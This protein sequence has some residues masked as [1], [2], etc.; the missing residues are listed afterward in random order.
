MALIGVLASGG[1]SNLQSIIDNVESGWIPDSQVVVVVSDKK[2]AYALE[3]AESHGIESLHLDPSGYVSREDYDKE[4]VKEL[5]KRDV[6]L[7][8]LAG[9]MR[10]ITPYFVRAFKDRLMN[11]HPALLPSFP[12]VHGQQQAFDYGV[13]V[14]GCTVHFVDE[15]VD[16]GPIIVQA[17][18]P[19]L[20]GDDVNSLAGRILE[21]EHLIYPQA[22]KWYVEGR[23]TVEGRRVRVR[24][25]EQAG[26]GLRVL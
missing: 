3:R 5:G 23:L 16:H 26:R 8:L 18:V 22:V 15:E 13:K 10:I 12:G 20:E 9:Y 2:D 17:A 19:V 14:S 25:V 24:G 11:I 4:V 21:Q 7:V 6:D 1:G